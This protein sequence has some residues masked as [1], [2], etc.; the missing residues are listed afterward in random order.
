MWSNQNIL[1]YS[2]TQPMWPDDGI[3][4][5]LIFPKIAQKVA[6]HFFNNSDNIRNS[7]K[8]HQHIWATFV[9]QFAAKNL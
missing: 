4:S 6:T 1:T 2:L 3:K 8:S 9:T 5:C 7:P